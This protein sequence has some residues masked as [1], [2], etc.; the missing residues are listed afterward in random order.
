[1]PKISV[2][3]SVFNGEEY[4]NQAIDSVLGQTF[5]D[6][7]FI[8]V[9]DGST[10]RSAEII[11]RYD[12]H[13]IVL[14]Q[15]HNQGI[16]SALNHALAIARGEYVARQDA[17][18]ISTPQRFARQVEFLDMH[19]EIG[20]VGTGALLIDRTGHP[21]SIVKPFTR[22]QRLVKELKRG[23]CPIVHGAVM[24]RRKALLLRGGYDPAFGHMQ[25]VELW[26]R[27]SPYFRLSNLRAILYQLRKHDSSITQQ[28]RIDLRI[29][30][31]AKTGKL[32]PQTAAEDWISFGRQFDGDCAAGR[33]SKAF[34]A[35]NRLRRAQIE[36]SHGQ[37]WRAARSLI[38][39]FRLNPGLSTNLPARVGRRFWRALAS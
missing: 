35:E 4:L 3:M 17:D 22:H 26:L 33:W 31:F 18:D 21:F 39:A 28:A 20:L 30:A 16:A 5:K 38:G 7:E 34:E 2:A 1:M 10:D 32:Q 13:R 19:A 27:L 29:R 11:R 36:F 8:I 9:D 23:V 24:V 37:H 6:F 14:L 25:D 12:D 15:Q